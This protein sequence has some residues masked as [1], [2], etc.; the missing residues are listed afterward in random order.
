[1]LQKQLQEGQKLSQQLHT[2]IE[3]LQRAKKAYDKAFKEAEKAIEGF[4]KA[5]ADFNLSRAEV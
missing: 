1:M 5:D 2:Q 4:Q 3:N